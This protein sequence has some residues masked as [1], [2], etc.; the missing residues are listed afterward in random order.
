M[1]SRGEDLLLLTATNVVAA[2][3]L[4]EKEF[5][6]KQMALAHHSRMHSE[7][8]SDLEREHDHVDLERDMLHD[9]V[10][11]ALEDDII[12]LELPH[13]R[14]SSSIPSVSLSSE[15]SYENESSDSSDD[16]QPKKKRPKPIF[17]CTHCDFSTSK[18]GALEAHRREHHSNGESDPMEDEVIV[19]NITPKHPRKA[20]KEVAALERKKIKK[21]SGGAND[22][23]LPLAK[24]LKRRGSD[25]K[26][27]DEEKSPSHKKSPRISGGGGPFQCPDC[28][29]AAETQSNLN[30]HIALAH[31][32]SVKKQF[33]C[34]LCEYS[35]AQR[36]HLEEHMNRHNG[37]N[38]FKCVKCDFATWSSSY[39][40]KHKT[41]SSH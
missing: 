35:S 1:S 23:Q 24:R 5:L 22:E 39:L 19:K 30:R 34:Q 17:N 20:K 33:A 37:V 32:S 27:D 36:H 26:E 13:A 40:S 15:E 41:Q 14:H 8:R 10:E 6:A 4:T 9:E 12:D 21:E 18:E 3:V 31:A 29:F 38:P 11:K 7:N 28:S 16:P 25:K 2:I